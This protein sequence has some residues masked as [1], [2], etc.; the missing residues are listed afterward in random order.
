MSNSR[1]K[2]VKKLNDPNIL[3]LQQLYYSFIFGDNIP[4][5][6]DENRI[7]NSGD[8][9]L[10]LNENNVYDIL[11]SK[12]DEVTGPFNEEYWQR[13]SLTDIVKDGDILNGGGK[14]VIIVSDTQPE[15]KSNKLW[16]KPIKECMININAIEK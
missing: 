3:N 4:G 8:V 1:L 14:N 2:F 11:A 10:Y 15:V 13:I 5:M 6:Y 12:E 7:Y 9:I 16:M